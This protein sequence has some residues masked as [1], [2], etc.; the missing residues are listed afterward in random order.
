MDVAGS[1]IDRRRQGSRA[2]PAA[3]NS[4]PMDRFGSILENVA[5]RRLIV[6][7]FAAL[8]LVALANCSTPIDWYRDM[9][10]ISKNDPPADAPNT[11][12]LEAG[13]E[14]PFP[15]LATVPPPPT[16]AL[17]TEQREALTQKLIA[18]RANAKYLDEELRAGPGPEAAPPPPVASASPAPQPEPA[19]TAKASASPPSA[20][21]AS[22][23]AAAPAA[24]APSPQAKAEPAPAATPAP[25]PAAPQ[26]AP[27]A[28]ATAPPAAPAAPPPSTAVASAAPVSGKSPAAKAPAAPASHSFVS[29][30]AP[31]PAAPAPEASA[32]AAAPS[33]ESPLVSP[34]V[35]SVPQPETPRPPPPAPDLAAGGPLA[36]AAAAADA[37]PPAP[38][39]K[40]EQL[41]A[42][43]PA[44]PP[45][46]A[47]GPA[48]APVAQVT[49]T[50][51]STRLTEADQRILGEVVPLQQQSGP[52][53]RV[54]G[55]AAKGRS[56]S[57]AAQL[58]S[59]RTALDR[60]NAVAAALRRAGIA[61]NQILVE[62]A[63]PGE[64]GAAAD[65]AEIFLEN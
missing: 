27:A 37:S 30:N 16:R 29:L 49:F 21:L 64:G 8:S 14:R 34:S 32:P 48:G 5:P 54:V 11:Q 20:A 55:H 52:P 63:P 46:P 44:P 36:M 57:A 61:A 35:R 42:R 2:G 31:E 51:N 53:V 10:G 43:S 17:S 26:T 40:A 33:R 58:A 47:Q 7:G 24:A 39:P 50:G 23:A 41:A 28:A 6:A 13:G 3:V 59:F 62:A 19:T 1:R 22:T 65:R 56:D 12:N 38:P 18:D 45:S 60:A 9:M 4:A 15:N 25:A